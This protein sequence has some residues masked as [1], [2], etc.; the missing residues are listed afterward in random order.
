[1]GNSQTRTKNSADG[2]VRTFKTRI[3]LS[4]QTRGQM[5][6]TLNQTL[7]D[8]FDLY[9]QVKQAHW[10]VKGREFYQLHELFDEMAEELVEYIDMVAERAT[11]LGG[12]AL[13]TVRMAAASS[14]IEEFPKGIFEGLEVVKA[15]ADRYALVGGSVREAIDSAEKAEDMTTSDLF[16]DVSHSLDKRLWF[17]EAHLQG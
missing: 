1:M 9:S 2:K 7:G 4:S 15:L 12:E 5:I 17:L 8:L 11:A 6:S 10:N 14:Q 13:G 16:I 3:D